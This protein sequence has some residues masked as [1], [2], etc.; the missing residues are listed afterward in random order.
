METKKNIFKIKSELPRVG[1]SGGIN[2]MDS[3]SVSNVLQSL[4]GSSIS[5]HS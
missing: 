1:S 2:G 4:D 5:G 3:Q